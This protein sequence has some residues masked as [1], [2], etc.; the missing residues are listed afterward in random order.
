VKF[1]LGNSYKLIV[2][3][4]SQGAIMRSVCTFPDEVLAT[5]YGTLYI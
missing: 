4:H 2:K 5:E 3:E 1:D